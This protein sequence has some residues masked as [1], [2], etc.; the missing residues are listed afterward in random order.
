MP[1][2]TTSLF[3]NDTPAEEILVM[4]GAWQEHYAVG[5]S[6]T[7]LI[8]YERVYVAY[9][10]TERQVEIYATKKDGKRKYIALYPDVIYVQLGK[11]AKK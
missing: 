6:K 10:N 3:F 4:A 9:M 1:E 11:E 8:D 5:D 2:R 7:Y